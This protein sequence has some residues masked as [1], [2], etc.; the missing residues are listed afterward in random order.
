MF[1]DK[2]GG[3]WAKSNSEKIIKI[4]ASEEEMEAFKSGARVTFNGVKPDRYDGFI[5]H[6]LEDWRPY[7][8][9]TEEEKKTFKDEPAFILRLYERDFE[10]VVV[11]W[12]W[13]SSYFRK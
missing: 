10:N 2:A 1:V 8:P 9:Y 12:F 4:V 13:L 6:V 11:F 5:R 7:E 3:H